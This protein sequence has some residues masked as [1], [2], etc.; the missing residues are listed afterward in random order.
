MK[1]FL[2]GMGVVPFNLSMGGE[3][4]VSGGMGAGEEVGEE[5]RGVSNASREGQGE[6]RIRALSIDKLHAIAKSEQNFTVLL[7]RKFFSKEQLNGH[8]VYGGRKGKMA[9]DRGL[10]ERVKGIHFSFYPTDNKQEVWKR[11]VTA[12]NTFLRGQEH[13]NKR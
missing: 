6:D 1:L 4:T 11:C 12:I 2:G 7:V 10:L 13:K 9:L 5:G 8:S 3:A